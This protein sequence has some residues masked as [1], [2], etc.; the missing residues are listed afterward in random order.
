MK[1]NKPDTFLALQLCKADYTPKPFHLKPAKDSY[2]SNAL[3]VLQEFH[4]KLT[5][6]Y[7]KT[8]QFDQTKLDDLLFSVHLPSLTSAQ[9]EALE[10]PIT[11]EEI[12]LTIKTLKLCKRPGPDGF[13]WRITRN[14]LS[15]LPPS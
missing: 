15:F 11:T 4:K 9:C 12:L 6:L 13:S 7:K 1:A 14:S 10:Q 3:K 5:A 8:S 2:T